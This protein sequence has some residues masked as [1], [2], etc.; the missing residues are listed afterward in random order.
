[1]EI[2]EIYGLSL[3]QTTKENSPTSGLLWF[4]VLRG[5][6]ESGPK[7]S[8]SYTFIYHPIENYSLLFALINGIFKCF[9][10]CELNCLSGWNLNLSTCLR[11][12]SY[13]S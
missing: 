1:M 8:D 10:G 2:C 3:C 12:A 11:I 7:I 6:I 9:A 4:L 5:G 13:P